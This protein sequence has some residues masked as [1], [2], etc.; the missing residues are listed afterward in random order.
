MYV[1]VGWDNKLCNF[2]EEKEG[3]RI[4]ERARDGHDTQKEVPGVT[5]KDRQW[6]VGE[7]SMKTNV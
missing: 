3:Y 6:D 4:C 2:L 5:H 7:H 1:D